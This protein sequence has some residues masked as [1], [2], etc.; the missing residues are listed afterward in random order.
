MAG[1][2]AKAKGDRAPGRRKVH[3]VDLSI[4]I[5]AAKPWTYWL[6]PVLTLGSVLGLFAVIVGYLVKVVAAK[7]PKT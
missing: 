7:Y 4:F 6:A 1:G 2:G 3:P 5:A